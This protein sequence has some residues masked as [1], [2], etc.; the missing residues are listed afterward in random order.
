MNIELREF[1]FVNL[2]DSVT[3]I[4]QFVDFYK[5]FI[6]IYKISTSWFKYL[7]GIFTTFQA[8]IYSSIDL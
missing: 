1:K 4:W 2:I 5:L 6:K 3:F 7:G 8:V